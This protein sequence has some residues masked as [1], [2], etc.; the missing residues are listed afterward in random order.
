MD[1]IIVTDELGGIEYRKP[2]PIS[3]NIMR[4]KLDLK[5]NEMVYIGDNLKK[6]FIGA[7]SLNIL[8]VQIENTRG[9]Y[10]HIESNSEYEADYK[11]SSLDSIKGICINEDR[12]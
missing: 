8:T 5:F 7:K 11:I 9:M 4:A 12:R 10:L 6:D 2:N 1:E 3:Y